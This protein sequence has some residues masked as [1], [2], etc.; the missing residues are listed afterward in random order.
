MHPLLGTTVDAAR[1]QELWTFGQPPTTVPAAP[2]DPPEPVLPA[3]PDI[4][5]LPPGAPATPPVPKDPSEPASPAATDVP[6]PPPRAPTAPPLPAPRPPNA[7]LPPVPPLTEPPEQPLP[8]AAPH[9]RTRPNRHTPVIDRTEAPLPMKTIAGWIAERKGGGRTPDRDRPGTTA[10]KVGRQLEFEDSGRGWI[11][12][13]VEHDEAGRRRDC[14][15]RDRPRRRV[16]ACDGRPDARHRVEYLRDEGFAHTTPG[17]GRRWARPSPEQNLPIHGCD[18]RPKS[19]RELRRGTP[20]LVRWVDPK[21]C[22]G[23]Q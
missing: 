10:T 7:P 21:H 19:S 13:P 23:R 18:G 5:P 16:D 20:C 22:V 8:I 17:I 3:A 1:S 4:P 9:S 12:H 14:H 2:A 6:P 15:T 11:V